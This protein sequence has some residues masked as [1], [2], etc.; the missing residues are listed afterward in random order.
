MT[1][2]RL[3]FLFLFLLLDRPIWFFWL[4]LTLC[5]VLLIYLLARQGKMADALL[6]LIQQRRASP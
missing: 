6:A 3:F 5:N 4:G 2:P 1:N